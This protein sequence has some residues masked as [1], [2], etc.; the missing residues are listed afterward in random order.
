MLRYATLCG[1][2]CAPLEIPRQPCFGVFTVCEAGEDTGVISSFTTGASGDYP[3]ALY[4]DGVG[5]S[6]HLPPTISRSWMLGAICRRRIGKPVPVGVYGFRCATLSPSRFRLALSW[7]VLFCVGWGSPFLVSPHHGESGSGW[8][9]YPFR[10]FRALWFWRGLVV[11]R[12]NR[13]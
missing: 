6:L 7:D 9:H 3:P 13:R 5:F 1:E 2:A 12:F 10:A 4:L 8:S 11:V